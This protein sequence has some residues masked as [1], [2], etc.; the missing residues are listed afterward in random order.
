MKVGEMPHTTN[1]FSVRNFNPPPP[2]R[3]TLLPLTLHVARSYATLGSPRGSCAPAPS[4]LVQGEEFAAITPK[5][6]QI[7]AV[8]A[9]SVVKVKIIRDMD[10]K[11]S[12]DVRALDE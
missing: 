4:V 10:K 3:R 8:S 11:P 12:T 2:P 6:L 5:R 9:S 7:P 1:A